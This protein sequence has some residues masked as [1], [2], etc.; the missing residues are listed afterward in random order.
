MTS[1]RASRSI[2]ISAL[3]AGATTGR[4]SVVGD[5]VG[6]GGVGADPLLAQLGEPAV[7][8]SGFWRLRLGT[9]GVEPVAPAS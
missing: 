4:R 7:P 2:L 8:A 9:H 1:V 6:V 3:G 5:R